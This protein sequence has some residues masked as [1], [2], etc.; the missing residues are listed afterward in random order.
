[1]S[2]VQGPHLITFI[3]FLILKNP[4]NSTEIDLIL[5]FLFIFGVES[6]WHK[7]FESINFILSTIIIFFLED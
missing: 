5:I 6:I 3:S 7:F 2:L 1:M 4:R